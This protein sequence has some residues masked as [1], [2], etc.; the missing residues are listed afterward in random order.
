MTD[1]L[2]LVA[3][4]YSTRD[5]TLFD[6]EVV[7]LSRTVPLPRALYMCMCFLD[8]GGKTS[9]NM[10]NRETSKHSVAVRVLNRFGAFDWKSFFVG[11]CGG[12]T[13]SNFRTLSLASM[14]ISE[15]RQPH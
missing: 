10:S 2:L 3:A 5:R 8:L 11:A 12:K 1:L 6:V 4:L 15:W 14:S 13:S 7:I 9:K